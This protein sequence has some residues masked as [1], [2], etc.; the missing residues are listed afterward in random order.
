MNL[1]RRAEWRAFRHEVIQ[2]H[3]GR[4]NRCSRGATDGVVLQAHHKIYI[5]GRL[6]WQY[7]HDECE[8]L[9]RGCHAQEHGKIMPES[10][11][12]HFGDCDDL[13][14]LDGTCELC[15]TSIRYVFP[16]YHA[17][18][19]TMEVGEICCDHLTSSTFAAE[20]MATLRKLVDRRKRFVSSLRWH[21][22]KS[23]S[24]RIVQNR[25]V[26]CIVRDGTKYRLK[27]NGIT[28]KLEFDSVF[29]AKVR[30]FDLIE[31]TP[32][33]VFLQKEQRRA[34]VCRYG[35]IA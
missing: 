4:C 30:A 29:E 19:G 24:P 5:P 9:C 12:E 33:K 21:M 18:W 15:G 23:G 27:M 8:A 28:G 2:L 1:Y 32:V 6:P 34:M 25:V 26:I 7:R 10:G 22:D 13:G 17:K 11:W 16:V 14:D 35:T 3:G 31:S 20:H